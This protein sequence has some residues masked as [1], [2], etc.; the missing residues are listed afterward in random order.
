M[1]RS[2][3]LFAEAQQ[4]L[5]GGVSRNAL[6]R[7]PHP[8]YAREARGSRITDVDGAELIDFANNMAS[9]IHGHSHPA[10]VAA[11]T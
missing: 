4:F 1:T 9:L 6:L 5:A 3:D 2:A 10:I 11:V 7:S 8:L